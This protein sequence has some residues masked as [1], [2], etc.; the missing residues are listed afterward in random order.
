MRQS[1][2]EVCVYPQEAFDNKYEVLPSIQLYDAL[3]DYFDIPDDVF[4]KNTKEIGTKLQK[5]MYDVAC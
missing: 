5:N 2:F 3:E 1:Y 4:E